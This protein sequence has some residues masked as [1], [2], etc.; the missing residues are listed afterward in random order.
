MCVKVGRR[1]GWER[2][3]VPSKHTHTHTQ[4]LSLSLTHT[5][6][7]TQ[8]YTQSHTH[9][10]AGTPTRGVT[11]TGMC[12]HA[13]PDN[14]TLVIGEKPFL[15][16]SLSTLSSPPFPLLDLSPSTLLSG[17]LIRLN[18]QGSQVLDLPDQL[19]LHVVCRQ[20]VTRKR[21]QAGAQWGWVQIFTLPRSHDHGHG[22]SH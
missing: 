11:H 9:T 13:P 7:H 2:L 4:S 12:T 15:G 3:P 14:S 6:S 20:H 19:S 10:H 5:Q 16:A 8:S 18:Q 17:H 1:P 21:T 22:H